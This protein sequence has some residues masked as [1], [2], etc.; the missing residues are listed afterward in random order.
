MIKSFPYYPIWAYTKWDASSGMALAYEFT[1]FVG[2]AKTG[3]RRKTYR[4]DK[5]VKILLN[6]PLS[7]NRFKIREELDMVYSFVEERWTLLS[8]MEYRTKKNIF[9]AIFR[10]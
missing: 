10:G 4:Y 9:D 8:K 5:V 1:R 6:I 7:P 3:G 2:E